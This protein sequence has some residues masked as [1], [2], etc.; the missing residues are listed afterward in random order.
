MARADTPALAGAR[1]RSPAKLWTQE[2]ELVLTFHG[3]GEP[4]ADIT[5]GERRVWVPVEWFEAVLDARPPAAVKIAFDD[6]NASD[7][8]HALPALVERGMHARF[9]PLAG[10]IGE[11]GYLDA[12]DIRNL[13]EAGM[14]IGSQGVNH[15]P[16]RTLGEDELEY[17]LVESRRC[18][19]E[20]VGEEIVEAACP[21]GSYDR[22][23]LRA[24]AQAGYE[25]VFNS[26]GSTCA[27][28]SWLSP[29]TTVHRELPVA[30][31]TRLALEGARR[32]PG[33]VL[34]GKRLIKRLR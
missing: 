20:I 23:V 14:A 28:G 6:G 31:W 32:R 13:R 9:F 7:V 1:P 34:L 15:R 8:V 22:R 18:L 12:E 5:P 4:D 29:R 25:R 10:R 2:R 19:S 16:W 21:F 26:D 30:H 17:E 33:P 11:P 27:E 3:L 24:L